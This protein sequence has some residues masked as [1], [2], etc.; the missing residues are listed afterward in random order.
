MLA[1]PYSLRPAA[2]REEYNRV[3]QASPW[4]SFLQSW[5]WGE[6]KSTTG[7]RA[8]RFLLVKDESPCAAATLLLRALSRFGHTIAYCPGGP[9]GN[10]GDGAEAAALLSGLELI[11]R[12]EKA[13]L[14]K[15]DPEAPL[16]DPAADTARL[17]LETSGWKDVSFPTGFG[18]LQPRC[19]M[20]L[21]LAPSLEDLLAGCK[22]KGRYNIRLAE[23]K[24]VEVR[25][26]LA[27]SDMGRFY[28]LLRITAQRD[29]FGVRAKSYFDSFFELL[30]KPGRA[31][32]WLTEFEGQLLAG[33]LS[34]VFGRQT[35]YLYGASAND[36][37]NLMPNHLMQWR[38]IEAA[39]AA[40]SSLYNFRGVSQQPEPADD[41]PLAGLN[42]FKE[43]FGARLVTYLGERDKVLKG[44]SYWLYKQ[45]LAR[46]KTHSALSGD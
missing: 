30:V 33:A 6:L 8:E 18:G 21:P 40:G 34:V 23:R 24:G 25:T 39:R 46:R 14:L 9:C 31:T 45:A 43:G 16:D 4:A 35:W 13:F 11:A 10:W 22:P 17:A 44:F 20:V 42:R 29:S 28:E 38:M 37:R 41:D 15:T 1:A 32:L 26:S 3:A 19:V 12:R 7:W 5:E 2:S 27:E 36:S